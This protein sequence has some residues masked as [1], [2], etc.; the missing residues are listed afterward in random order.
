MNQCQRGSSHGERVQT[1]ICHHKAIQNQ[2]SHE[3]IAQADLDFRLRPSQT[4]G[5]PP[6]IWKDRATAELAT[7]PPH[8][9]AVRPGIINHRLDGWN[10]S[11][12]LIYTII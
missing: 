10:L 6:L 12:A 2:T 4:N 9:P 3:Y 11:D 5:L 1:T 7:Q 8:G